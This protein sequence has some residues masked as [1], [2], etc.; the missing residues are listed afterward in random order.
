MQLFRETLRFGYWTARILRQFLRVRPGSTLLTIASTAIARITRILAFFLPLKV[1]LLA[2][3]PGVPRYFPFV[4]PDAKTEWIVGLT[5]AA[6]IAYGLTLLLQS[7]TERWSFDAG[8]EILRGANQIS[9]HGRQEEE[10]RS[11]FARFSGVIASGL[12]IALSA[13]LL[14]WLNPALLGFISVSVSLLYVFTAWALRGE[15][16][17]PPRLKGRIQ[18]NLNAYLGLFSTLIFFGAFVVILA[19]F[20]LDRGGNILIALLSVLLTQQILGNLSSIAKTGTALQAS[21]ARIDPL[22][23]P[24]VQLQPRGP[25]RATPAFQVVF[26]KDRRQRQSLAALARVE[27]IDGDINV[28]WEDS[29]FRGANTLHI[30]QHDRSGRPIRHYQQQIFSPAQFDLLE[31]EAVLFQHVPRERLKAPRQ[32]TSFEDAGFRCQIYAYGDATPLSKKKFRDVRDELLRHIWAYR[33]AQGLIRSY[34]GS[35]AML[36]QRLTTKL[37]SR[38]NMV[39]DTPEEAEILDHWMAYLPEIRKIIQKQP[40][41]LH[42]PDMNR[43]TVVRDGEDYLIMTWGR[44]VLEPLGAAMFL[45]GLYSKGSEF[46]E[47][48]RPLRPD[49]RKCD[50]AADLRIAALCGQLE[51]QILR[52]QYK[53]AL[54]TIKVIRSH[55][56]SITESGSSRRA[57]C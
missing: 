42:N 39:T 36:H 4:S 21:R 15:A 55:H 50:W 35:R 54:G 25:K 29:T 24:N 10:A 37:C 32:Y 47:T 11:V 27:P 28:C 31:N 3:S 46:L 22:V 20:L 51:Q 17:P 38:L 26:A 45:N 18:K 7:A 33:P 44:W 9:L 13:L 56:P 52:E 53:A 19:P 8:R 48:L 40:L 41:V 57:A 30:V 1:I 2:G 6:F 34:R 14:T 23:Y 12:F 43:N 49:F 16:V 5:V